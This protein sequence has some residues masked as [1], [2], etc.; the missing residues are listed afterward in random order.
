MKEEKSEVRAPKKEKKNDDY[1]IVSKK[2][3]VFHGFFNG[4]NGCSMIF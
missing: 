1:L 4:F 2:E 3:Q